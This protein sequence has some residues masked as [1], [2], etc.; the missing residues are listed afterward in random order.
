MVAPVAVRGLLPRT[1]LPSM[2]VT[3]PSGALGPEAVTVAVNVMEALRFE[4]R[5]DDVIT[6]EVMTPSRLTT[7]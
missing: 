4:L 2:K 6:V 5:F 7:T 1:A 3:L